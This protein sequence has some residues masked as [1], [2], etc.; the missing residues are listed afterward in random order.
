MKNQEKNFKK[1]KRLILNSINI[2]ND[3]KSK[4][5]FIQLKNRS[6]FFFK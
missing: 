5:E 4:F 6:N 1:R 3:K 2:F